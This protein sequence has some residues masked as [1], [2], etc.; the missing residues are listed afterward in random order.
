MGRTIRAG[1]S[2]QIVAAETPRFGEIWA[3][4]NPEGAVVVHRYLGR[5]D[6][7]YRFQGDA[8][9]ADLPASPDLIIGRVAAVK[10]GG[11]VR[12]VRRL[13]RWIGGARL[14]ALN[15]ARPAARLLPPGARRALLRLLRLL[16][17]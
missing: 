11:H 7:S 10:R 3:F 13:D 5:D 16:Q 17:G 4:C 2:V 8:T 12:A 14:Q 6:D 9:G 15:A 1:S